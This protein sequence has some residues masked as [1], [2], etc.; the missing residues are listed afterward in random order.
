MKKM[1][2]TVVSTVILTALC[3]KAAY[4][5]RGYFAVGGEWLIPVYPLLWFAI[6]QCVKERK[7]EQKS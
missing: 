6:E 7:E 1:L 2:I 4:I 3:I 5:T